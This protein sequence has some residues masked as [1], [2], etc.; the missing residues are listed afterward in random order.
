[1]SIVIFDTEYTTWKG[2]NE[3]GWHGWQEKEVV[4][5][6]A[7]RINEK[8]EVLDELC[9]FVKPTINP[10]LSDYFENLTGITNAMVQEKGLFYPEAYA[11]F[12][13]FVGNDVCWSH[14]WGSPIENPSDG[15]IMNHNCEILNLPVKNIKYKNV[16]AFFAEMYKKHG[17]DIKSQSS[18][19]IA[20]LLGREE[21]LK[22]LG[23]SEH[24]AMYDV[25]SIIEGLRY[26]SAESKALFE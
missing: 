12:S 25:Y 21:N 16:A 4:Q 11:K 18:G 14:G 6:A 17:I 19:M 24:N 22:N 26:F 9:L 13:E 20:R 15:N 23:I 3:N 1:M 2:C 10:V 8:L 7:A 5:I